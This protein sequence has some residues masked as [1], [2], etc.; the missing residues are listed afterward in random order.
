MAVSKDKAAPY[1]SIGSIL[2]ILNRYRSRGMPTPFSSEVLGRAGV[3]DSLIPRT[4]QSL[5]VLELMDKNGMPTDTLEALRLAPT[6]EY[7]QRL[8]E[9]L[10]SV[11]ADVFAFVEPS[12][13]DEERIRDAFRHYTPTGQQDR[14]VKLF[15]SLCEEAGIREKTKKETKPRTRTAITKKAPAI[16]RQRNKPP[17]TP[18][19]INPNLPSA[20]AGLIGSLPSEDKGWTQQQHDKFIKTFEAVLDFCYPIVEEADTE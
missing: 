4:L 10:K 18:N 17:E 19:Q 20:I 5:Q 3:S 1:A 6:T 11:Y 7:P 9:W 13:D 8:E 2:D 14:M 15:I 16:K 12:T